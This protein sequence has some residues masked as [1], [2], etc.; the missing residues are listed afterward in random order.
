MKKI[1][2]ESFGENIN[3]NK[4]KEILLKFNYIKDIQTIR[5]IASGNT[6]CP[7]INDL[8][9]ILKACSFNCPDYLFSKDEASN[10][11]NYATQYKI[12]RGKAGRSIKPKIFD[13]LKKMDI[14][15]DGKP[16]RVDYNS[17]GSINL[18]SNITDEPEA[19][20]VEV[21]NNYKV[22]K[23]KKNNLLNKVIF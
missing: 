6:M 19:W 17:D 11:Y 21:F 20:I 2:T 23:E 15:F 18:G 8:I 16:L 7:N 10:I 1:I 5:N 22:F 4:F 14:D 3:I 13:A 9:K 12:L